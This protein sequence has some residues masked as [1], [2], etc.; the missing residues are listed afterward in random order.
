MLLIDKLLHL[1]GFLQGIFSGRG[2]GNS[3]ALQISIVMLIFLQGES[4]KYTCLT[5]HNTASITSILK[6]RLALDR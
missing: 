6:N 3:I 4:K 5:S 1:T 2:E